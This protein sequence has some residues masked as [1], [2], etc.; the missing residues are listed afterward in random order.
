MCRIILQM[1]QLSNLNHKPIFLVTFL[2][3][4][5]LPILILF[6]QTLICL[7]TRIIIILALHNQKIA[8]FNSNMSII[9]L[10]ILGFKTHL[11]ILSS[12]HKSFKFSSRINNNN[13]NNNNYCNNNNNNWTRICLDCLSRRRKNLTKIRLAWSQAA[14]W[15]AIPI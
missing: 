14:T 13:S 8:P 6:S 9:Y 12:R 7:E 11:K 10:I 4:C 2:A 15:I 5:K 1:Q 3:Q